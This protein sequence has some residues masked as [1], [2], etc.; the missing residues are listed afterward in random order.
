M[1]RRQVSEA[2]NRGE[3]L[4]PAP[5]VIVAR[6]GELSDS[7]AVWV[8]QFVK[9]YAPSRHLRSSSDTLVVCILTV[10]EKQIVSV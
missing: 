2:K 6:R 9:A 8:A 1:G 4:G 10:H 7:S 5:V 3:R